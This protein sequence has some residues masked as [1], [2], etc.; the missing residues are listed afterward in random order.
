M[1]FVHGFPHSCSRSSSLCVSCLATHLCVHEVFREHF[2]VQCFVQ[3]FVF[4]FSC[5]F[6]KRR[7][8]Y[9]SHFDGG[10]RGAGNLAENAVFVTY[11]QRTRSRCGD[12]VRPRREPHGRRS[13][14]TRYTG[15]KTYIQNF[16]HKALAIFPQ[17]GN[18][19]MAIK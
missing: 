11:S 19:A 10:S 9:R 8:N 1:F 15:Y 14:P 13:Q 7:P 4:I 16:S 2:F 3:V 5:S 18:H 17:A 12:I 6:S